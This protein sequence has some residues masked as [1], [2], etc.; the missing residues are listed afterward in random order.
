M[1]VLVLISA[2]VT[3]VS[4]IAWVW[5]LVA[6]GQFWRTDLQLPQPSPET[7]RSGDLPAVSVVVP[8]RN[9]AGV[10]PQTLPTLL[11][12]DYPGPFHVLLV[13]DESDDGT[14]E[15]A[16][17]IARDSG[18]R[19]RLTVQKGEP[20]PPGW[21]GKLWALKQGIDA[22]EPT[23]SEFLL[24]TDADIA[25]PPDGL[26]R[27]VA[28]AVN[29][30]LDLVSVMAR[31]RVGTL[32]D[33]LLVPAFV[34][35]FAKLY[36]FR[37]V[38][39]PGRPTAAAAGGCV[40]V[41]RDALDRSGGLGSISGELIDDCALAHRVKLHGRREGG[42]IW[43]G[44][45]QDVRSLRTYSSLE[46]VWDMVARSAYAQLGFSPV[47]LAGTAA[48]MLLLYLVPPLAA[49]GGLVAV[50]T[51]ADAAKGWLA[52]TGIAAWALMSAIYVPTLR[53]HATSGFF[54]PALPIAGA[55]YTAMTVDSAYRWW[56]GRGGE[57]KGRTYH[58]AVGVGR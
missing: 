25:H 13:D 27:L 30:E 3:S 52:A 18:D 35:F 48:G 28:K 46:P 34:F 49:I 58:R 55:L 19:R 6:R 43:L 10:L 53:W 14:A 57:W 23:D 5:L 31:L 12:Q 37:W 47:L 40:L 20:L 15:A 32:W 45:S 42:R 36:P 56:K 54:A 22:S 17:R 38:A 51:D 44:L 2:A 39:D 26:R 1:S 11:G 4:L 29:N 8:A 33:R 24:L 7:G 16:L 41:R 9:E 21:T 50:A